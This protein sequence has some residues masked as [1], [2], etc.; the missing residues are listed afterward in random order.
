MLTS[1]TNDFLENIND[2][3]IYKLWKQICPKKAFKR[4]K[5]DNEFNENKASNKGYTHRIV[6]LKTL[7]E[8]F[9]S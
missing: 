1:T 4:F 6:N 8:V 3:N 7:T 5:S 9:N 2:K